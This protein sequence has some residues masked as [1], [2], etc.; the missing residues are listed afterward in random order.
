MNTIP[1]KRTR[2][3]GVLYRSRLEAGWAVFL[4]HL[5]EGVHY[6]YE[7]E[8]PGYLR[9]E[10]L[11]EEACHVCHAIEPFDPPDSL[12]DSVA[13]YTPDFMVTK[14]TGPG[15][16]WGMFIE[17]K[18]LRPS[19]DYEMMLRVAQCLLCGY[20]YG[21]H[22]CIGGMRDDRIPM[23]ECLA[24]HEVSNLIT[25]FG[26]LFSQNADGAYQVARNFRWDLYREEEGE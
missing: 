15:T 16:A 2:Y 11:I 26:R 20:G 14:D 1:P 21:L 4:D 24:T 7:P 3:K 19:D 13:R 18:P 8:M 12:V 17:V 9:N 22:L 23:M 10:E 5:G 6:Y 25:F